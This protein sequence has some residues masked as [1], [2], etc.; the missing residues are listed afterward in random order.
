MPNWNSLLNA[1]ESLNSTDVDPKKVNFEQL[2]N[3]PS[4]VKVQEVAACF[5]IPTE[6]VR[7][8][9]KEGEL[10]AFDISLGNRR[11]YRILKQSLLDYVKRNAVAK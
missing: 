4:V 5:R 3:L 6:M 9:I 8:L 2:S 1:I 7:H 10:V 11:H